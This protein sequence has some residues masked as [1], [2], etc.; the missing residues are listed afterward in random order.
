MN[1]MTTTT[2]ITMSMNSEERDKVSKKYQK[3]SQLEHLLKRPHMYI[4]K[5]FNMEQNMWILDHSK[6]QMKEHLLTYNP[7]ILKLFDEIILNACDH[8]LEHSELNR[9]NVEITEKY[10][11]VM[12]NGPGIPIAR[13]SE[14]PDYY[15]P[16][17]IFTHFLTSS[18]YD[19]EK[20]RLK[21]GLNG[22]GAK[23]TS[24][25]SSTFIIDTV[26]NNERYTQKY[27]KNLSVIDPPV[28]QT[29]KKPKKDYT[30]ITFYPDFDRFKIPEKKITEETLKVLERRTYDI[31]AYTNENVKV[32]LNDSNLNVRNFK[33]YVS[34]FLSDQQKQ[35]V[36]ISI[37]KRW[38]I[39]ICSSESN[40]FSSISFVNGVNTIGGGTHVQYIIQK[41]SSIVSKK[42]KNKIR[43]NVVKDH[44]MIIIFAQIENPEFESQAKE[45]LTTNSSDFGSSF[46]FDARAIKKILNMKFIKDLKSY[47]QFKE[48]QSLAVGDGKKTSKLIGIPNLDDANKA[49]TKEANQCTLFLTEG[50]SAK[51][52]AVSGLS[53]IGREY[54][55]IFPLKGKLINVRSANVNQV[56]KNDEIKYI[57]QILGLQTNKKYNSV[58][59]LINSLRYG[60]VCLLTD[61]DHDAYH[62]RGLILNFFHYYWPSLLEAGYIYCL[63]TPIVKAKKLSDSALQ[64]SFYNLV[65][66][67]KWKQK[68]EQEHGGLKG[69][70]IKYYKGLGSSTSEEAKESF[71]KYQDDIIQYAYDTDNNSKQWLEL[72]F[73]KKKINERKQWI[74]KHTGKSLYLPL[75]KNITMNDFFN[76]EFVQYSISDC[77]RSIPN[78]MD[79]LKPSQ[80]K[81]LFGFLKKN[82]LEELKVDQIRGYVSEC[83]LYAHG[84]LSLNETIIAMNQNYVGSNNIN[85][86]IPCGA[87]GTRLCGGKDAA[88]PRYISTK[89]NKIVHDIFKPEDEALLVHH[90]EGDVEIE[91]EYYIPIIPMVLVNG[92]VGIGTGYAS[93]I[94]CYNPIDI[95]DCLLELLENDHYQCK[96]LPW[97]RNFTGKISKGVDSFISQGTIHIKSSNTF[98]I[99]ELPIGVW[100][101]K[102]KEF[103][104]T[105]I[106]KKTILSFSDYSTEKKVRIIVQGKRSFIQQFKE[107]PEKLLQVFKLK[108]NIK[109]NITLFDEKH[110]LRKFSTV[111][112]V[113]QYFYKIRLEYYSKRIESL[114]NQLVKQKKRLEQ[115]VLFIR[116]VIQ[117]KIK[118][119]KKT[120][121]QVTE[122]LIKQHFK[123]YENSFDY[124]LDLRIHQFTN[125][126]V[127]EFEAQLEELNQKIKGL[128]KTNSKE[129]WKEDLMVLKQ[130]LVDR[131]KELKSDDTSFS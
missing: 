32:Y 20:K 75:R 50:L 21:S 64:K 94:P 118:I 30:K 79:G 116:A 120:R 58:E 26:Y 123:K 97:Y 46:K 1:K 41:L 12:N 19:D 91:P 100:T 76:T 82:T 108:S 44:V 65:E 7:G 102:Y 121:A 72:A 57:K 17:L 122:Q 55:G 110:K 15:I 62:I 13:H 115:K 36:F 61:A 45:V 130:I 52:F 105:L 83:T 4:G 85:L 23:I 81:I 11:S 25:F 10:I 125:E 129:F 3:L 60:K 128:K 127:Q 53:I 74:Q 69:W 114:L 131:E 6:N 2:T 8:S 5:I 66:Y 112:S 77:I 101:Q 84:D 88:S 104:E 40:N 90:K 107:S 42:I 92:A 39:A 56:I 93:D 68:K 29:L 31:A 54:F 106:E 43:S 33:D 78:I 86:F 24:A 124:L 99:T 103:L 95:I 35:E 89:L 51:T 38:K 117:N 96:L 18:N 27:R 98:E 71:Q 80:R 22:L 109:L 73:S 67:D 9:I 111:S 87:F 59:E 28:I 113:M 34:I 119:F 49:G 14:Y 126:R 70:K 16:E 63:Q 47:L 48:N 37:E